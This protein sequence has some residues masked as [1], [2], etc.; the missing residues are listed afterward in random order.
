MAALGA[1]GTHRHTWDDFLAPDFLVSLLGTRSQSMG[2]KIILACML[3]I[4]SI[5]ALRLSLVTLPS[6]LV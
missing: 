4:F 5:A 3:K 2:G 6:P 1:C